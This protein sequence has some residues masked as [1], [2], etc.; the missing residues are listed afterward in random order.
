M[1]SLWNADIPIRLAPLPNYYLQYT[2][3]LLGKKIKKEY[4]Q[5]GTST[6]TLATNEIQKTKEINTVVNS[7]YS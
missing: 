2:Q 5:G 4:W 7:P 1:T 6:K 3:N